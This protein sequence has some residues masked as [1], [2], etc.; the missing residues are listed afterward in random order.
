MWLW[1]EPGRG[2]VGEAGWGGPSAGGPGRGSEEVA[3]QGQCSQGRT[4]RRGAGG[5]PGLSPQ[6]SSVGQVPRT[7]PRPCGAPRVSWPARDV[8]TAPPHS[9][10]CQTQLHSA[11]PPSRRPPPGRPPRPRDGPGSGPGAPFLWG[12]PQRPLDTLGGAH[13]MGAGPVPLLPQCW[14]LGQW[15]GKGCSGWGPSPL[16]G[17]EGS[18]PAGAGE[19]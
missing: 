1:L 17:Q 8:G 11:D 10:A 7:L 5:T 19:P 15:G 16:E 4:G 12:S 13:G 9:Q 14:D 6:P 2:S 18:P 3:G